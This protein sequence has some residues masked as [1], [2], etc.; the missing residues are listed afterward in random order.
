MIVAQFFNPSTQEADGLISMNLRPV[1]SPEWVPSR[2]GS[3]ATR[4]PVSKTHTQKRQ[5]YLCA[6]AQHQMAK[7]TT[8]I[9][10]S[11]GF[12]NG[13]HVNDFPQNY[14]AKLTLGAFKIFWMKNVFK[15]SNTGVQWFV[16]PF[17]YLNG[18]SNR[19]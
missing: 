7:E 3:K 14:T 15:W 17:R 9:I 8:A 11:T 19:F 4:N 6:R 5:M 10:L 16:I 13:Y 18:I 2:T 1:W 12:S